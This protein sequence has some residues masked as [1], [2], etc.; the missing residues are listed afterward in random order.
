M[1]AIAIPTI[2]ATCRGYLEIFLTFLERHTRSDQPQQEGV[3]EA[4]KTFTAGETKPTSHQDNCKQ[5]PPK[6]DQ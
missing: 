2:M 4:S 3:H 1:V 5:A 6:P